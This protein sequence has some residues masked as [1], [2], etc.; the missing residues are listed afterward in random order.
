MCAAADWAALPLTLWV[1]WVLH[2]VDRSHR[3][4][5][6]LLAAYLILALVMVFGVLFLRETTHWPRLERLPWVRRLLVML[7]EAA[8]EL[9]HSP[10]LVARGTLLQ[11]AIVVLDGLTLWTLLH[12]VGMVTAPT[13]AVAALVAA[14]AA[15]ALSPIPAGLGTFEGTAVGVLVLFDTPIVAALAATLLL[16]GFALWLPLLPGLWLTRRM[17]S[18]Y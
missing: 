17:L 4:L 12:A 5:V 3:L 15:A 2:R 7:R 16:R 10:A 6:A 13:A 9:L 18:P 14:N 11:A 1:L 8:P